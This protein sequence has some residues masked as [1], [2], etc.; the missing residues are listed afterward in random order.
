MHDGQAL[1]QL[2]HIPSPNQKLCPVER[3]PAAVLHSKA[4]HFP[5]FRQRPNGFL[6]HTPLLWV[7]YLSENGSHFFMSH[8]V[9]PPP[10]QGYRLKH[11][12]Q[13]C[14]VCFCFSLV[15]L[16]FIWEVPSGNSEGW[17]EI[18]HFDNFKLVILRE[19][20]GQRAN[21]IVLTVE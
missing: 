12:A 13:L 11:S 4:N 6:P 18:E 1:Y 16:P 19:E 7:K 17:R 3:M 21:S 5:S 14:S 9:L 2:S 15:N 10:H 20:A 8:S